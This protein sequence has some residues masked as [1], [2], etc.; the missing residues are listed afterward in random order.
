[1]RTLV[2]DSCEGGALKLSFPYDMEMRDILSIFR[3][4]HFPE[5]GKS[6]EQLSIALI[7]LITNS[8][9]AQSEIGVKDPVL[10]DVF[11]DTLYLSVTV[12][13]H[14]GGFDIATLPFPLNEPIEAIDPTAEAFVEYRNRHGFTRF[15]MGLVLVRRTFQAF[16]LRF[17]D[18]LGH[19]RAWPSPDIIGTE[20]HLSSEIQDKCGPLVMVNQRKIRRDPC[21]ARACLRAPDSLGHVIDISEDGLR[22]QF[23]SPLHEYSRPAY[24]LLLS[25]SEIGI[26]P[27]TIRVQPQWCMEKNDS[28]IV[29]MRITAFED[30]AGSSG[31][32]ALREYYA[33]LG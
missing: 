13:D 27:F 19:E 29:G 10:L 21:L 18:R 30:E 20:I 24:R 28:S 3:K 6:D 32:A 14:G 26:S 17:I 16:A 5:T 9:R 2:F 7:E 22:I 1:M 33:S 23:I 8:L 25:M 31:F 15:G 11:A 12:S 4:I